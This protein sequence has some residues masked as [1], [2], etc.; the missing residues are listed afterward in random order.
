MTQEIWILLAVVATLTFAV[1]GAVLLI[2]MLLKLRRGYARSENTFAL[3][4]QQ[5]SHRLN[6][7]EQQ[8]Q[9][10]AATINRLQPDKSDPDTH[11]DNSWADAINMAASGMAVDDLRQHFSIRQN[12][13]RL[14]VEIYGT[15]NGTR[16][17]DI[18]SS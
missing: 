15:C 11:P 1:A 13:A 10:Q 6:A 5:L 12:E 17:R 8:A 7:V 3:V 16:I 2:C 14:L 18:T 9:R 4:T